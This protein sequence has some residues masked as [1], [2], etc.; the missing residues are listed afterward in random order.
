MEK[1][2][3]PQ[4]E[5]NEHFQSKQRALIKRSIEMCVDIWEPFFLFN[6]LF[7]KFEE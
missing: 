4:I 3:T 7:Q 6:E 5:V 2:G 1:N